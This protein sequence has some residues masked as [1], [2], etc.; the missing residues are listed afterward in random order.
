MTAS[1]MKRE[2]QR[3]AIDDVSEGEAGIM[4][5]LLF[6]SL[7]LGLPKPKNWTT[8]SIR[9]ILDNVTNTPYDP[10][11]IKLKENAVE[12]RQCKQSCG[13]LGI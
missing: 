5:V 4:R 7:G 3:L 12:S 10:N 13:L 6:Q 11:Q 9:Y 8:K 2:I 1:V